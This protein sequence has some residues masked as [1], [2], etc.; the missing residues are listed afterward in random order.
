M[1]ESG[2]QVVENVEQDVEDDDDI[3]N[4]NYKPPE[5][6]SMQ[7]I[8][9]ADKGDESLDN[10]KKKLMGETSIPVVLDE[11]NPHRVII[12][13]LELHIED[14]PSENQSMDLTGDVAN[15]K[16]KK[17][18][19]VEN[20]KY[21]ILILFH[22]QREIVTGLQYYHTAKRAGV[23]V[24]KNILMMGSY[25]PRTEQHCFKTPVEEAPKGMLARGVY[26]VHSSFI[27]DDAHKYIEFD[28]K[29][30]IVKKKK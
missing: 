23:K 18:E 9:E 15:L 8:L 22:V 11:N 21:R 1:A 19:V 3:G 2:E 28:W 24:E 25:S 16:N 13:K 20:S 5:E 29:L 14:D 12:E 26:N 17:F 4:P 7:E 6:K 10:Y 27:D 30:E